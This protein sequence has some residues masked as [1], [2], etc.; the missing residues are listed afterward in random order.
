MI[1]MVCI[2][3]IHWKNISPHCII[4]SYKKLLLDSI[5]TTDPIMSAQVQ[6]GL[7]YSHP[8]VDRFVDAFQNI[9]A[10]T[11]IAV[12]A[13][14]QLVNSPVWAR[15]GESL[16]RYSQRRVEAMIMRDPRI[17]DEIRMALLR[18]DSRNG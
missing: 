18:S 6:S 7:S 15:I 2:I 13:G 3:N 14:R 12:D 10:L 4:R 11:Q 1:V 16:E 17:S 9:Q 8:A 5:S